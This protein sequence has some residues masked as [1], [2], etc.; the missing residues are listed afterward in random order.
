MNLV[1]MG[2]LLFFSL[3]AKLALILFKPKINTKLQKF[4]RSDLFQTTHIKKD[5]W[6]IVSKFF[7]LFNANYQ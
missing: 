1:C 7:P 3:F 6:K 5:R 2:G 4:I